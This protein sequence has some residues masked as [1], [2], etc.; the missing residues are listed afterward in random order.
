MKTIKYILIIVGIVTFNIVS[1]SQSKSE[2]SD[3]AILDSNMDGEIDPYEALDV[4]LTMQDK[5]GKK[6]TLKSFKKAIKRYKKDKNSEINEIFSEFDENDNNI[7][8]F[9]E[10]DNEEFMPFI[11]MMDSDGSK[12]V[13]KEEVENFRF[14][15][16]MFLSD[17]DLK[18]EIK[19]IFKEYGKSKT[20][21]LSSVADSIKS[22]VADWDL[23]SDGVV[24][25]Q[26]AFEYMK[27]NNTPASFNVKGDIAYMS[28]VINSSTPAKVLELVNEHPNVKTIEMLHVPGSIDDVSNLRASLYIHKFGL[29]TRL[30]SKSVIASGGTDFFLAGKVRT[31][32]KGAKIGVHSWGGGTK[33]ATDLSKSDKAHKKY[34]NY[35]RKVNI[36]EEF[37]WY[38]LKAAPADDIHNMT[39]EEIIK[40]N[41][42]TN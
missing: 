35:Y 4:L 32:V 6:L 34:L 2:I 40:Y 33:A 24:T 7:V 20:I 25:R 41:V 8:E 37:Y 39:E 10:V 29:N 36:P 31:V 17:R 26:E 3:F 12:S 42:R 15:D 22:Q 13:T 27:P 14:E 28:G 5:N 16:A 19:Q 23:N 21:T 30:N 1:N 18:K 9:Y 38:T 11:A